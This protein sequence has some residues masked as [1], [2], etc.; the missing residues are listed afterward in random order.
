MFDDTNPNTNLPGATPISNGNTPAM[1]PKKNDTKPTENQVESSDGNNPEQ[2][3]AQV[4]QDS[5]ANIEQQPVDMFEESAPA[6]PQVPPM[7]ANPNPPVQNNTPAPPSMAQAPENPIQNASVPPTTVRP[8]PQQSGMG[9]VI[10]YLLL[11]L[12]IILLVGLGYG[13]Y[14]YFNAS[15]EKE[16]NQESNLLVDEQP[17]ENLDEAESENLNTENEESVQEQNVVND[18]PKEEQEEE[19]LDDLSEQEPEVEVDTD[20]DGL[21]DEQEFVYG[22]DINKTD[23]DADG[24]FDREEVV[25]YGTDPL[26]PD[27]DGDGYKDGEEIEAGYD[28][29]GPGKLNLDI[30]VNK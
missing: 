5:Q 4:N 19:E 2:N 25:K 12:A 9:S 27:T 23:T 13:A 28:P 15:L 18:I 10:K 17:D 22:T 3:S 6:Q 30:P 11:L 7:S 26:N 14:S 1:P 29:A 24:L 20:G 8:L 21:T 16:V